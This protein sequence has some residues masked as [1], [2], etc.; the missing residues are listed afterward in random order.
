MASQAMDEDDGQTFD[1]LPRRKFS[2]KKLVLFVILPLLLLIGGGGAVYFSGLLGGSEDAAHEEGHAEQAVPEPTGPGVFFTLPDLLVNLNS[3]GGRRQNF[4][5]I[6][7]SIELSRQED[8]PELEKV[9]PR[10]IDN[11]QV[12]LREL[13]LDDLRGSAGI[14]RLREELLMRISAAAAPVKVRDVLFREM[15]VQ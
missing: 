6:S 12:Y 15:L 9:L 11:F 2:G 4:L 3:P 10:I 7:I 13:R 5:K 14:Y 8:V 1:Q